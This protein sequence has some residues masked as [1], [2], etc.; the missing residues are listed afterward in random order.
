MRIESGKILRLFTNDLDASAEEIAAL[1]KR[2]WDIELFFKWIKQNLKIKRFFGVNENAV[3][4]QI[5]VALIAYLILHAARKATQCAVRPQ[6]FTRLVRLNLM[7]RKSIDVLTAP[8]SPKAT[9]L[10]SKQLTLELC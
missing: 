1:Y 3:R 6:S 8:P 9:D 4:T 7:S 2:R 5:Y 10:Q